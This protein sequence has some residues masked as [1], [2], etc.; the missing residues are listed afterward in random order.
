MKKFSLILVIIAIAVLSVGCFKTDNIE[1][2]NILV[3]SYPI[4]FVVNALYGDNST[5]SSIYPDGT[6]VKTYKFNQKQIKDFSE[7]DL[8]IYVGKDKS[9]SDMAVNIKN[10]NKDVL[11]I[12]GAL[13]IDV[14]DGVEEIWLNPSDLLM[15]SQNIRRGLKEYVK[16]KIL[17]E[18]IDEKYEDL[19]VELS[20]LDAEF[21]TAAENASTK[22]IIA[23]ND[24]LS[25]LNK[26]GFEV[27]VYNNNTKT[28]KLEEEVINLIQKEQIKY[29][30]GIEHDEDDQAVNDLIN[31]MNIKKLEVKSLNTIKD[32]DRKNKKDYISLMHENIDI[33]KKGTYSN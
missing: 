19:K 6:N 32:E 31:K 14:V 12:D 26:Y 9:Q 24:T 30:Y 18:E 10:I 20:F 21:K 11:L 16:S 28:D 15:A 17:N 7:K 1:G 29:I 23:S 22:T 2:I 8:Y 33:L 13:G 4:E 27:I 25:Y 5:I 3:T